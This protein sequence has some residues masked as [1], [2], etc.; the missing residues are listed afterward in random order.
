MD[1][2]YNTSQLENYLDLFMFANRYRDLSWIERLDKKYT[3]IFELISPYNRIVVPYEDTKIYHIGSRNNLTL[4]EEDLDI[5][6]EK[7]KSYNLSSLEECLQATEIMPFSEEGYVVV[8]GD[9]NRIK[10]KSPSYTAAHLLKNNGVVTYSRVLN[11]IKVGGDDDFVSI[12]P[13][14][15]ALFDVIKEKLNLFIDE[16][17][18]LFRE[19]QEVEF[20]N[21]KEFALWATSK[22]YPSL[23]FLLADNK[24]ENTS[25]A[26]VNHILNIDSD[27]LTKMIG[28][29]E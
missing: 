19:F 7:P 26:V 20:E 22:K 23:L 16:C 5:G 11:V 13:E 10:I 2:R 6:I 21:R 1:H 8:D 25:S 3:Y 28:V 18:T 12:Y 24:I 14:Y 4:L 29:K 27:K 15:K 9:Y 17:L